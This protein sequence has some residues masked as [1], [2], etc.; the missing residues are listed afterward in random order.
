MPEQQPAKGR[1]VAAIMAAGKGSRLHSKVPKVLHQVAGRPLLE[2]VL[3][4]A[5]QSGCETLLVIVGHGAN[6]VR[7]H[8]EASP[9]AGDDIVWVHQE[10][11]LG[12][13]HALAQVEPHVERAATLLVLSGDVPLVSAATLEQLAEAAEGAWGSMAVAELPEP[14]SLGRVLSSPDG[15]LD[16]IVEAADAKPEELAVRSVNAGLYALPA[17][18]IFD[19]LRRLQ[20]DNAKGELYLTDALSLA[21]AEEAAGIALHTLGDAR[22][23]LGVNSRQDLARVHRAIL[24]RHLDHLMENGVT[25]LEP[26]RTVIEPAVQL[27]ADTVIEAG[28]SLL[29]NSQIGP[30]CHIAQGAWIRDCRLGAGVTVMPYSVLEGAEVAERCQIGPFARLRPASVL[31]AEAR[32]GNFVELK[33]TTLGEGSKAS[34]LTYL[35]DANIGARVNIGAGTVTCN[36]DGFA[37]HPTEIGAG[38]FI[39]SDTMLVA[40][41]KV[42]AGATT[43][44]GSTIH[45]DVPP[46][47]LGVARARQKNLPDWS[48]KQRQKAGRKSPGKE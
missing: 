7:S 30:D 6:A 39:G 8:I 40:P 11:Q 43:G 33:K 18:S 14:G 44:A 13:G 32:V 10:E 26:H 47:A 41:V 46:G 24:D 9:A 25:I 20:P 45:Q 42:G 12:T 19:Y 34:H 16:R 36:Y 3:Q 2:W 29:G 23:A 17:P 5:R 4:A 35:G 37:K 27:A 28:V 31:H 1:R 22:E 38:A 15:R 48:R 21:A